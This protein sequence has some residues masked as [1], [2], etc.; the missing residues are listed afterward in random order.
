MK[1]SFFKKLFFIALISLPQSQAQLVTDD[2]VD[3]RP[4]M[5]PA[6][7]Q[8]KADACVFF[9]LAAAM[10]MYPGIP[11]LSETLPY[12]KFTLEKNKNSESFIDEISLDELHE[13]IQNKKIIF[14]NET[15]LNSFENI[16]YN[17]APALKK[18]SNDKIQTLNN[19]FLNLE[20]NEF[21]SKGYEKKW[22]NFTDES[23][24][25]TDGLLFTN[26]VRKGFYLPEKSI[27]Y[28]KNKINSKLIKDTLRK[29][30]PIIVSLRF[31][32]DEWNS[33]YGNE[34]TLVNSEFKRFGEVGYKNKFRKRK[35]Q[36]SEKLH[37]ITIVGYN[38]KKTKDGLETEYIFRNSWGKDWGT[39]GNGF[40]TEEYLI[41]NISSALTIENAVTVIEE[42]FL[43]E[44]GPKTQVH[45]QNLTDDEFKGFH[46]NEIIYNLNHD[47]KINYIKNRDSSTT[48]LISTISY[49]NSSIPLEIK[50]IR[51]KKMGFQEKE[52]QELKEIPNIAFHDS[53]EF[54]QFNDKSVLIPHFY[55][56]KS[57]S[58]Q[59]TEL[60]SKKSLSFP[61][62][63][64]FIYYYRF[65]LNFSTGNKNLEV[66][67]LFMG[68]LDQDIGQSH[69]AYK[70]NEF[71]IDL[72]SLSPNIFKT[73]YPTETY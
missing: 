37:A 29:K 63:R 11:K 12:L 8:A 27:L 42:P 17:I 14:N 54:P 40:I 9:A 18:K 57:E 49:H 70:N 69:N 36:Y 50:F 10:E 13:M 16:F 2:G 20:K 6:K 58:A 34:N 64:E 62:E 59:F 56:L 35:Y 23:H 71:F 55:F 33:S 48:V 51:T 21:L 3:L 73:W 39:L 25:E 66:R 30:I 38:T 60:K 19:I 45:K 31:K 47:F 44:Y 32:P 24:E 1:I 43:N 46:E 67:H 41:D 26:E 61:V 28:S 4:L 52:K 68:D 5:F 72:N 22:M 53:N 7:S 15:P 65:F